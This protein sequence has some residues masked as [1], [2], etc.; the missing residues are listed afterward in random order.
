MDSLFS[1]AGFFKRPARRDHLL[2]NQDFRAGIF[3]VV[4]NS[5][6]GIKAFTK[7]RDA[8]GRAASRHESIRGIP[9]KQVNRVRI[10]M[11][12]KKSAPAPGCFL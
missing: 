1:N 3:E 11:S 8:I 5:P 6:D 2:H 12:E 4:I 9:D 7:S 10:T